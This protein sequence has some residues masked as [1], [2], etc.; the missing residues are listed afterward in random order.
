MSAPLA[1][2]II[3]TQTRCAQTPLEVLRARVIRDIVE[4]EFRART[5]MSARWGL[6]IVTPMLFAQI[7]PGASHVLVRQDTQEMV[8]LVQISTNARH[9]PTTVM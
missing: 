5:S 8:L 2:A 6:V 3:A 4:T 1:A 7:R 9:T